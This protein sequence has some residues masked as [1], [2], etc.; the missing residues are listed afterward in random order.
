V[1]PLLPKKTGM[2]AYRSHRPDSVVTADA[3]LSY[4]DGNDLLSVIVQHPTP[5]DVVIH[6][7]GDIDLL[8]GPSLQDHLS[9]L[10]IDQPDS[11]IIDLRA[12]SFVGATGLAV[13]LKARKTAVRQRTELS[14]RSPSRRVARM[15][16]LL[17]MDHLFEVAA[18]LG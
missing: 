18:E 9:N 5:T 8:T 1:A 3:V 14:L 2:T 11:L 7:A 10:L 4:V 13:L 6:V 12:I 17:A 15:L 16:K